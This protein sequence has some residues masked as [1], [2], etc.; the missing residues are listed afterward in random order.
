[1]PKSETTPIKVYFPKLQ[2]DKLMEEKK[3]SGKSISKIV[4]G[5]IDKNLPSKGG[6][7]G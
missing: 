5:L 1:M 2:H 3:Q 7:N 6:S 4:N